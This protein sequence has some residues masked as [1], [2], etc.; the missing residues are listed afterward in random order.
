MTRNY[1]DIVG[2]MLLIAIGAFAA[3]QSST[4]LK[5]GTVM[6][7]GSGMFPAALGVLLVVVG[8]LICIP[9]LLRPTP[10]TTAPAFDLRSVVAI[11]VGVLAFGLMIR[12]FGLVPSVFVLVIVAGLAD[13]KL[14]PLRSALLA[15]VL[16]LVSALIFRIGLSVPFAIIA[17]P[18]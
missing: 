10:N 1:Q 7:M 18:W 13:G 6:R 14:S 4:V 9:A 8:C 2:G 5:L 16:A 3:Y 17:W 12:P 15:A 11:S